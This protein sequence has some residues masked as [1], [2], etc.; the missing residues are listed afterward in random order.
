MNRRDVYL[1][2]IGNSYPDFSVNSVISNEQGQNNDILIVNDEFIFRFPKYLAGI[3][4]LEIEVAVLSGIR[5]YIALSI[6][7]IIF[8]NLVREVGQA[9]AG[10]RLIPG[11]PLRR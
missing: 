10:Y 1:Q 5:E 8:Q 4:Q 9:F 11:E 2:A 6:P 3:E 7:H